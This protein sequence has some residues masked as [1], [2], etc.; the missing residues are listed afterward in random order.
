MKAIRQI[1]SLAFVVGLFTSIFAGS[2]F[3]LGTENFGDR[4]VKSASDWPEGLLATAQSQGR[5]YWRWVNGDEFFCYRG[6]AEAFNEFLKKF[7]L[8]KTSAHQ[9]YIEPTYKTVKT[10]IQPG[11]DDKHFGRFGSYKNKKEALGKIKSFDNKEIIFDWRLDLT[12]LGKYQTKEDLHLK[13]TCYIGKDGLVFD[14]IIVPDNIEAIVSNKFT[15]Q[16]AGR[17]YKEALKFR[18]AQRKWEEFVGPFLDEQRNKLE[19]TWPKGRDIPIRGYVEF[20]SPLTKKI[21][22]DYKI[23][24]IETNIGSIGSIPN[25][26]AVS[27][28]GKIFGLKRGS[29][30]SM[31]GKEGT[32]K[33]E[34]FS[35]FIRTQQIVVS[36]EKSAMEAG[37]FIE[38]LV[39][40]SDRWNYIR[41]NTEDFKVFKTWVFDRDVYGNNPDWQRYVEKYEDGWIVSKRYVGPPASTIEPR[42]WKLVLDEEENIIEV[43]H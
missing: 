25:L 28:E 3:G 5:V 4:P 22:T 21:L 24:I 35:D 7:S 32:F 42:R 8:I 41:R 34:T 27:T 12:R 38:E 15:N 20:Q 2:V 6:G 19:K 26:F 40:A 29:F 36:D 14:D 23:Y 43:L 1:G 30:G 9:L 16:S 17:K 10:V 13:V 39:F 11:R 31:S 18:I 37:Q 33:N